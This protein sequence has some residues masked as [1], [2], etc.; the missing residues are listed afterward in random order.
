MTAH[1][2]LPAPYPSSGSQTLSCSSLHQGWEAEP[3]CE[4]LPPLAPR[5]KSGFCL[6]SGGD[7]LGLVGP[8]KGGLWADGCAQERW[9]PG[10]PAARFALQCA[11]VTGQ[12]WPRCLRS[13]NHH[14]GWVWRQESGQQ[15]R[16]ALWSLFLLLH[17]TFCPGSTE[18]SCRWCPGILSP[19]HHF[20]TKPTRSPEGERFAI[21]KNRFEENSS[22]EKIWRK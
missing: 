14:Q 8:G 9:S 17:H 15:P 12:R 2:P 20:S 11:R 22:Q 18:T 16:A 21:R 10:E 1:A 13:H 4:E 3:G 19:T 5:G 6:L 7:G